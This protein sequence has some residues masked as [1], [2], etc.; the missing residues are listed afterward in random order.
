M[1]VA[2]KK[3]FGDINF[4]VRGI[5]F[6][7]FVFWVS[8]NFLAPLFSV[9][10]VNEVTGGN[11]QIVTT[12]FSIHLIVRMVTEIWVGKAFSKL[13]DRYLLT[14]MVFGIALVS[15]SYVVLAIV[16]SIA[17]IYIFYIIAGIGLGTASPLKFTLLS[18]HLDKHNESFE[19]GL[20][21]AGALLGSAIASFLGGVIVHVLGFRFLFSFAGF[22]NVIALIPY[23]IMY[24]HDHDKERKK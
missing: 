10:V 2:L 19:F 20:M 13:K 1:K 9:F 14:G 23:V 11:F 22:I 17:A 24:E 21:D 16:D 8:W 6:S 18:K 4:H 3:T 12:S 15:V 7:E 5:V